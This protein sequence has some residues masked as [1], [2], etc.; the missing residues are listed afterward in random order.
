MAAPGAFSR[1]WLREEGLYLTSMPGDRAN[2]WFMP[3]DGGKPQR[4]TNFDDQRIWDFAVSDDGR[5]LAVARGSR[6]RDAVLIN[7][8]RGS[9]TGG[10]T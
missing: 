2:V 5:T 7:G 8:F 10:G 6:N 4:L 9:R 1:L 3:L